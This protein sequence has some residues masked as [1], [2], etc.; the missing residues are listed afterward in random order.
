[1]EAV[2]KNRTQELMFRLTAAAI[3]F[4]VTGVV[5]SVAVARSQEA[6]VVAQAAVSVSYN[7]VA[8]EAVRLFDGSRDRLQ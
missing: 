4:A 1:M 7:P 8:N 6:S 3:G 5:F 2:M